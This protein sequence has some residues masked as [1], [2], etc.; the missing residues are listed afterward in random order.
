MSAPY[1]P[2]EATRAYEV[3]ACCSF[4][5]RFA[6]DARVV[7]VGGG[8][9]APGA[10]LLEETA[11]SVVGP[12]DFGERVPGGA[13]FDLVVA[14]AFTGSAEGLAHG[15]RKAAGS[16]SLLVVSAPKAGATGLLSTLGQSFG[17]VRSYRLAVVG[18]A[19]V[20]REDGK[21]SQ[22]DVEGVR[23]FGGGPA[24]A[25]V[26]AVCGEVGAAETDGLP[27]LALDLDGRVF[28]EVGELVEEVEL[29][30]GEILRMQ[31]SEAQAFGDT[32]TLRVS[33][34]NHFKSLLERSEKHLERATEREGALKARNE[35]LREQLREIQSSGTW[36]LLGFYRDLATR[37]GRG[38]G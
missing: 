26:L 4:A 1:P 23:F 17:E 29:L 2:A 3:L 20:T 10:R 21:T 9:V 8:D 14:P 35:D 34:V 22:E 5:R 24:T 12:V 37:L 16:G 6:E 15:T 30:R 33:E 19:A 18:G 28:E 25:S 36:R 27:H 11:A 13:G 32:L 31:E 7:V 38:R